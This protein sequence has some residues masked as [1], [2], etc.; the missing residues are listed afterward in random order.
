MHGNPSNVPK[1]NSKLLLVIQGAEFCLLPCCL[2]QECLKAIL[3]LS[4][5]KLKL[6]MPS[7][8]C[9]PRFGCVQDTC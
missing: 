4:P 3:F 2:C 6:L 7:Y 8:V 1:A 9:M 5:A